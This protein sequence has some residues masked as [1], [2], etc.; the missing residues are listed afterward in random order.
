[1]NISMLLLYSLV[2]CIQ[3]YIIRSSQFELPPQGMAVEISIKPKDDHSF[4]VDIKE[5]TQDR[6]LKAT[7]EKTFLKTKSFLPEILKESVKMTSEKPSLKIGP[8]L[9]TIEKRLGIMAGTCPTGHVAR[10]SFC[11]PD[12]D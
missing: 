10:G 2:G 6:I 7:H 5:D 12:Y 3:G 8:F 11:F 1:M 4:V 9:P